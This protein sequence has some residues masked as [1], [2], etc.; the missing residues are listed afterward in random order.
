M[1]PSEYLESARGLLAKAM[2][3]DDV[4]AARALIRLAVA[5]ADKA[6]LALGS[7]FTPRKS[8]NRR[9]T[10]GGRWTGNRA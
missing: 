5:D 10:A 8:N 3:N 2:A 4:Q 6:Y 7:Q 1:T 9:A